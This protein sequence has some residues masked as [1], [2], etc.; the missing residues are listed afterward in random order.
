M[1]LCEKGPSGTE[2]KGKGLQG[3]RMGNYYNPSTGDS[4]H[5]DLSHGGVIGPHWDYH[6][7]SD[8]S[9]WRVY[10]DGRIELKSRH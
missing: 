8:N 2:W 4:W 1:I 3:S 6:R 5:P 9:W 10:E 7:K